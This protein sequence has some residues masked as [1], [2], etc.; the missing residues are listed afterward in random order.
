MLK[1]FLVL[2]LLAA[3]SV[4][5][6]LK[7]TV[8]DCGELI[9]ADVSLFGLSNEETAVRELFVPCYL[10][11][12]DEHLMVWDAGLPLTDVGL[13]SGNSRYE[14]SFLDQLSEITSGLSTTSQTFENFA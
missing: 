10:I 3:N 5:A 11:Q 4:H 13:T 7:L 9:F 14:K 12:H 6:Q 1:V 8:F 2:I